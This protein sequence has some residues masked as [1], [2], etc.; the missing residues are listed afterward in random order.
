MEILTLRCRVVL[1][2]CFFFLGGGW[3]GG[4]IKKYTVACCIVGITHKSRK[5]LHFIKCCVYILSFSFFLGYDFSQILFLFSRKELFFLY[6]ISQNQF[7]NV[8]RQRWK[9]MKNFAKNLTI[10]MSIFNYPL[11]KSRVLMIVKKIIN[12]A[13]WVLKKKKNLKSVEIII[14]YLLLNLLIVCVKNL[15]HQFI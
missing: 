9:N 14:F 4:F 3:R 8:F 7:M 12:F 15:F 11:K 5:N 13:K 10:K 2:R 6:S 1:S